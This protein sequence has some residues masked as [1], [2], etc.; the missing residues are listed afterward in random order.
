MSD[1]QTPSST[2]P[3]INLE[4]LKK[5]AKDLQKLHK[6]ANPAAAPRLQRYLPRL[7]SAPSDEIFAR[8]LRLAEA[9]FVVAQEAGFSSWPRLVSD[10]EVRQISEA[11]AEAAFITFALQDDRR[12]MARYGDAFALHTSRYSACVMA[13]EHDVAAWGPDFAT[14]AGGPLSCTPLVYLC[15]SAFGRTDPDVREARRAMAAQLLELGA[16]PSAGMQE[17]NV[18]RG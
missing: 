12:G 18:L 5:R 9:Q 4:Q 11:D 14:R 10:L 7:A 16:D 17:P 2:V 8:P 6:Q 15:C 3:R 1:Q 13:A